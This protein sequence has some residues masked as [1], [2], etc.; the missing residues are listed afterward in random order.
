MNNSQA[1]F[2]GK[3]EIWYVWICQYAT[4]REVK[5]APCPSPYRY[6]YQA[7]YTLHGF[8]SLV[9]GG[10]YSIQRQIINTHNGTLSFNLEVD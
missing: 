2:P 1:L 5:I 8:V 4:D 6:T 7:K 10:S 3:N 9:M